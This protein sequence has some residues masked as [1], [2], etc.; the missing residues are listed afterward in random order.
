MAGLNPLPI[1]LVSFNAVANGD[2]VDLSWQ[3]A[4]EINNAYFTIERSIDG[5]VWEEIITT[6]GAG[7]SNQTIEYFE[8]DYRIPSQKVCLNYKDN[9]LNN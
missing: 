3:T 5:V 7:N 8:T 1:E 6:N 2:V 4:T 9:H